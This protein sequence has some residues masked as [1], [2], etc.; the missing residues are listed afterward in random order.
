MFPSRALFA[1]AA[2]GDADVLSKA[3]E[4]ELRIFDPVTGDTLA[5]LATQKKHI[6]VVRVLAER[7]PDILITRNTMGRTALLEAVMYD[8]L[9][10]AHLVSKAEPRT[11]FLK[12]LFGYS[13]L[14]S[15][16]FLDVLDDDTWTYS[17]PTLGYTIMHEAVMHDL[18]DVV[19]ASIRKIP[20]AIRSATIDGM[21]PI[22]FAAFLGRVEIVRILLNAFP[23]CI[24]FVTDKGKTPLFCASEYSPWKNS[25]VIRALFKERPDLAKVQ[26]NRGRTPVFEISKI[27]VAKDVKF[28]LDEYPELALV[29]E[30]ELGWTPLHA[31]LYG[32]YNAWA[33]MAKTI[34]SACPESVHVKD[35]SGRTP[36]D[37]VCQALDPREEDCGDFMSHIL[38]Y[39]ELPDE[40]WEYIP[41]GC[42]HASGALGAALERSY[43]EAERVVRKMSDEHRERLRTA[44][45]VISREQTKRNVYS[46]DV[47]RRIVSNI[48]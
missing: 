13:P 28:M 11:I 3:S 15:V 39:T 34:V 38:R 37:H 44:L 48:F 4:T 29:R 21:T 43:E 6:E 18:R 36:I 30:N 32:R 26:D 16:K 46:E 7:V 47:T 35:N 33:N 1:A 17:T 27:G 25:E 8:Y 10:I 9:D 5:H 22:H 19:H 23:E 40:L 42:K 2:A 12:D 45:L 24:E 41:R 31:S 20:E 14:A